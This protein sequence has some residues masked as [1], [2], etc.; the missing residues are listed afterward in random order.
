ML[1]VENKILEP[2]VA[3]NRREIKSSRSFVEG[4]LTP[5]ALFLATC[6][7]LVQYLSS[8]DLSVPVLFVICFSIGVL[9]A[10]I[11]VGTKGFETT[12]GLKI[13][14]LSYSVNVLLA[15]VLAAYYQSE[16]GR[17][18]LW[19]PY[20]GDDVEALV[21]YA[22]GII[23]N[24]ST[25]LNDDLKFHIVGT[26]IARDWIMGTHDS[27][28]LLKQFSYIGYPWLVGAILYFSHFFGDMS[29]L[30]P[31]IV[32]SMFGGLLVVSIYA[33]ASSMY[34]LTIGKRVAAVSVIFPTVSFYAANTFRD[35]V[36]AFFIVLSTLLISRLNQP[37]AVYIKTQSILA[38]LISGIALLLLRSPTLYT[39]LVAYA[40]YFSWF[41]GGLLK[42][43]S[44][45][46][47]LVVVLVTVALNVR[48]FSNQTFDY[49]VRQGESWN[50][51]KIAGSSKGSL[52]IKYIF[53]APLYVSIPFRMVYM[54]FMPVPPFNNLS[55]PSLLEGTGA[56][57]WYFCV[58][59][60]IFGL[61][62]G[63]RDKERALVAITCIVVFLSV[64]YV[65]G[66]LRHKTQF[67]VLGFIH[68]GYA[69]EVLWG[70]R[71]SICLATALVL[72]V[73]TGIY[74]VLKF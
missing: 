9:M 56:L 41:G 13:F 42:R 6:L 51:S 69:A 38:L 70:R 74:G 7:V 46:L 17:A 34:G 61:W 25:G 45:G 48:S 57:V 53:D 15:I 8:E 23:R 65:G 58:P 36:V 54:A 30:A 5:L 10:Y 27:A 33:L 11:V 22:S 47:S 67:M 66:A 43:L 35:I 1:Q 39:L 44:L 37:S 14:T 59:F 3:K 21:Q 60:W 62:N 12:L 49:I 71:M 19:N 31:R 16:Y 73:L 55:F 32:N 20:V 63:I 4:A 52:A 64:A 24:S 72:S 18:F 40:L 28:K 68:V 50:E 29:P 26:A 2:E